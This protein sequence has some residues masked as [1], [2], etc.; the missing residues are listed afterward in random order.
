[1]VIN[2]YFVISKSVVISSVL[3]ALIRSVVVVVVLTSMSIVDW[4]CVMVVVVVDKSA[5]V[6]SNIVV[7]CSVGVFVNIVVGLSDVV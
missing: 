7:I 1:M 6:E 5:E 3:V 2:V 4:V